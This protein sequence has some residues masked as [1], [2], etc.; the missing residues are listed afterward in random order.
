[1]LARRQRT[2]TSNETNEAP[3]RPSVRPSVTHTTNNTRTCARARRPSWRWCG[4]SG[5]ARS[6]PFSLCVLSLVSFSVRVGSSV[7]QLD[8]AATEDRE[9]VSLARQHHYDRVRNLRRR[10]SLVSSQWDAVVGLSSESDSETRHHST[11]RARAPR[12]TAVRVQSTDEHCSLRRT[13]GVRGVLI[14]A[15]A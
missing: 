3:V 1:M 11:A 14:A 9:P 4:R 8:P 15:R 13:S 5:R 10:L 7:L 2:R 6:T 12:P